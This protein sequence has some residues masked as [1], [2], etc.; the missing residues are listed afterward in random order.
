MT[1]VVTVLA[2]VSAGQT[3]LLWRILCAVA[4]L[5]KVADESV[6][7]SRTLHLLMETTESGFTAFG[8]VLGEALQ[9]LR[10]RRAAARSRIARAEAAIAASAP[11]V[12]PAPPV[13]PAAVV[14]A[15]AARRGWRKAGMQKES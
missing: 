2:L 10:R 4:A 9:P 14:A 11:V 3:W 15:S 1:Y 13:V 12:P 8:G 6:R 5:D 7:V